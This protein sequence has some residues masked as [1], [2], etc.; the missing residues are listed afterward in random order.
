MKEGKNAGRIEY[1][2]E[3]CSGSPKLSFA[4]YL[5]ASL[6]DKANKSSSSPSVRPSIKAPYLSLH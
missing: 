1:K 6:V 3:S 5:L 4:R 2:R